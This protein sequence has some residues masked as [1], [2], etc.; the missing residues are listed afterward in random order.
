MGKKTPTTTTTP[1]AGSKNTAAGAASSTSSSISPVKA[2]NSVP[3]NKNAS[4]SGGASTTAASIVASAAAAST[5]S[6]SPSPKQVTVK[7]I[8]EILMG[9]VEDDTVSYLVI[10][11]L[12]RTQ[13]F[14]RHRDTNYI[15]M[16][17]SNSQKSEKLRISILSSL[18]YNKQLVFGN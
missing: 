14:L 2:S 5:T 8:G 10:D 18:R 12:E 16:M 6:S 7:Q 17:D 13:T 9:D 11:E 4:S 3:A 1:V 15:N